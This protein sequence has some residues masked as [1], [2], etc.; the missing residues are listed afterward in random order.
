MGK[1]TE[2]GIF[3]YNFDTEE[4]EIIRGTPDNLVPYLPYIPAARNLFNLYSSV[5]SIV[6]IAAKFTLLVLNNQD[7]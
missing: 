1:K 7:E 3:W 4:Y 5:K 6:Q 2:P